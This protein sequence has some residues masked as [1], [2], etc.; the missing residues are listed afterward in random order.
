M[1]DLSIN[2]IGNKFQVRNNLVSIFEKLL[3]L[4]NTLE[5]NDKKDSDEKTEDVNS[6]LKIAL[7][8]L[9]Q[10]LFKI[11]NDHNYYWH[12][13]T[14][15]TYKNFYFTNREYLIKT[16]GKKRFYHYLENELN[17]F[18]E[19]KKNNT[20]SNKLNV[21]NNFLQDFFILIDY[22]KFLDD[23]SAFNIEDNNLQ[24]ISFL[25][26]EIE[27]DN[28]YVLFDEPFFKIK[29]IVNRASSGS[30]SENANNIENHYLVENMNVFNIDDKAFPVEALKN[31][32]DNFQSL[33]VQNQAFQE[34]PEQSLNIKDLPEFDVLDRYELVKEL[35]IDNIIHNL[36]TSQKSKYKVLA[37]I[38]GVH[39]ETTRKLVT[40][41]Y[42]KLKSKEEINS[43]IFEAN[44][45][46]KHFL[47]NPI[48]N[49]KI[50]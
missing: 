29:K 12:N 35:K 40:N 33:V 3:F 27:K 34:Y 6:K 17:S 47:N 15:K 30:A 45:N 31:L 8:E 16:F 37:L 36:D 44:K 46:V 1:E 2:S 24:K 32:M 22:T 25:K 19:I 38:M 49:I 13:C 23:Y 18:L 50:P 10:K 11:S 42:P 14:L 26:S 41:S 48:N 21:P 20:P 28:Y 9:V 7:N 4:V 5:Q 43:L 39:P